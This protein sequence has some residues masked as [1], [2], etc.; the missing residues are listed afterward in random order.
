MKGCCKGGERG[1][2]GRQVCDH[3]KELLQLRWCL[4]GQHVVNGSDLGGVWVCTILVVDAAK[5]FDQWLFYGTFL[6]IEDKSMFSGNLHRCV[7]ALIVLC[8]IASMD[9]D[10]ICNP[11]FTFSSFQDLVHH[12]LKDSWAQARPQGRW[13]NL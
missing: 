13:T 11:S 5:T 12:M 3:S 1:H 10:I 6:T 9:D 8:I 7:Q 2:E 4:W